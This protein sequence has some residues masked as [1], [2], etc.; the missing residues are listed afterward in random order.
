MCTAPFLP[1][2]PPNGPFSASATRNSDELEPT[3]FG[4][5]RTSTQDSDSELLR[6][7]RG[8]VTE[9]SAFFR[10]SE[11]SAVAPTWNSLE[12]SPGLVMS[13]EELR[14]EKTAAL[15]A[16][17]DAAG[18]AWCLGHRLAEHQPWGDCRK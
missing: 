7:A 9:A 17:G 1:A 15:N 18:P 8:F 12:I 5:S 13:P 16:D 10:S 11:F 4:F 6:E 3:H 2:N 14:A